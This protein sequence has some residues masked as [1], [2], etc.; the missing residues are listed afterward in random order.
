MIVKK[1][2]FCLLVTNTVFQASKGQ[3]DDFTWNEFIIP[4]SSSDQKITGTKYLYSLHSASNHFMQKEWFPG[5]LQTI[6]GSAYTDFKLRYDALNDAVVAY[7]PKVKGFF[8]VDKYLVSSFKIDV[9]MTSGEYYRRMTLPEFSAKEHFF[10]VLH[11]DNAVLLRFNRVTERKTA[12]YRNVF[13]VMDNRQYIL[14]GQYLLLYPGG[15]ATR[16]STGRKSIMN[17]F[18]ERK[19]ELRKLFREEQIFAFDIMAIPRIIALLDRQGYF[20]QRAK[21]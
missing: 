3:V 14:E 4:S 2:L 18:P 13:G 7:N 21:E 8:V 16:I 11:E 1:L 19:K 15:S 9:P 17:L 5:V 10:Q 12:A 20:G 6:D